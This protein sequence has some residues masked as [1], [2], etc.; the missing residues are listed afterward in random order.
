MGAMY[1]GRRELT[2]KKKEIEGTTDP[3]KLQK[4]NKEYDE[5]NKK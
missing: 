5:L 1:R 2:K 3:K 4:L